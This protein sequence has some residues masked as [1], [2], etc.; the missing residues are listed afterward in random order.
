MKNKNF[1]G[2]CFYGRQDITNYELY[3][4]RAREKAIQWQAEF[5]DHN[6]SWGELY[7]FGAYFERLGKQYGLIKEFRENGI[8]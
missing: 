2:G 3:K 6:Y 8:I 1:G 7:E 5:N 4:G